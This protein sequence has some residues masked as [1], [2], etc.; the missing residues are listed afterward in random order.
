MIHFTRCCL[1]GA[2]A[3]GMALT[4]VYAQPTALS[5]ESQATQ[6]AAGLEVWS[7]IDSED[8]TVVKVLG[9][10]FWNFEER[11]EFQGIAVERAWFRPRGQKARERDRIYV[12]L[13]DD[14]NSNWFWRARVGT[15]GNTLIGSASL[16]ASD[17]S[18]EV[19]VEREIVDTP[20]GVDEGIYYTFVGASFDLAASERDIFNTTVGIQKFTGKNGRLHARGSYVHVIKSD[21][22]LTA[23][24]RGRYFYSTEPGEFD[25]YSPRN[26]LQ[27]LPVVQLRRFEARGWM[28]LVAL[29]YGAQKATH[30]GWHD[31]RLVDFRVESPANAKNLQAFAQLQYTNTSL[32]G[33]AGE[34]H[35]AIARLGLSAG[36][37]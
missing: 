19:F 24:L 22:G 12:E 6:P 27:L 15:D 5:A 18:R 32:S 7:S 25:Y 31:A 3:L 4:P 36:F 30:S 35:Y 33:G 16:R 1:Q 28:Y 2:T 20:R 23:Q 21:I 10:A 9:R 17:W 14:L 26:F 29:G 34:Y 11:D 37:R 8:T 13:A